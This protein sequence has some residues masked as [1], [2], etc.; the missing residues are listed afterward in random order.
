MSM[1]E[2]GICCTNVQGLHDKKKRTDVFDRLR[3]SGIV[4]DSKLCLNGK[5]MQ[6]REIWGKMSP[7]M[8]ASIF[9]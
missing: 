3:T 1:T 4:L 5:K 2:I 7:N 8:S 9:R 6:G